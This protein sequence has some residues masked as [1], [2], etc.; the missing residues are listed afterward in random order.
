MR[1]AEVRQPADP[2]AN[3]A[4]E[5]RVAIAPASHSRA[6]LSA[7]CKLSDASAT[8]VLG[9]CTRSLNVR[10]KSPVVVSEQIAVRLDRRKRAHETQGAL[11]SKC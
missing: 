6:R 9:A 1:V 3:R 8:T 10:T 4:L 7:V 11:F 5:R 2:N